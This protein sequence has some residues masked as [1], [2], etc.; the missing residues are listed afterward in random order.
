MKFNEHYGWM[1]AIDFLSRESGETWNQ[2]TAWSVREFLNRLAF[3][4]DKG[5]L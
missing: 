1:V 4:K 5:R 3:Y 2:V